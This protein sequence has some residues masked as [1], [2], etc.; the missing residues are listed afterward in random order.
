MGSW[1]GQIQE[2]AEDTSKGGAGAPHVGLRCISAVVG[3]M[4][5]GHIAR[6]NGVEIIGLEAEP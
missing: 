2:A 6:E 4:R 1:N 3:V 5:M